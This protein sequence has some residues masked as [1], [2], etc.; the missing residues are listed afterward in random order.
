MRDLS[1]QVVH[2]CR[3]NNVGEDQRNPTASANEVGVSRHR[4]PSLRG[5]W[6][7]FSELRALQG[8]ARRL[9]G[10][11]RPPYGIAMIKLVGSRAL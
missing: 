11:V 3:L 10:Q 7:L 5:L 2:D 9:D 8:T 1:R 4:R 6:T